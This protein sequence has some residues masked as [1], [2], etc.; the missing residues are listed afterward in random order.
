MFIHLAIPIG[1]MMHTGHARGSTA[2]TVRRRFVTRGLIRVRET[3]R[4]LI[5]S[6]ARQGYVQD[7]WRIPYDRLT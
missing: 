4:R 1:E 7:Y 2:S 5:R 6:V 3:C